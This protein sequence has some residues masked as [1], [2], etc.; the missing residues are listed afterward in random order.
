[1]A[2]DRTK[3]L[4]GVFRRAGS[5]PRGRRATRSLSGLVVRYVCAQRQRSANAQPAGKAVR[6]GGEP[7]MKS[8]RSLLGT[9]G[10][11]L[12]SASV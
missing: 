4:M 5:A 8:S 3:R 6:S 10:P 11:A 12:S 2:A 7:A 9:A 1:M